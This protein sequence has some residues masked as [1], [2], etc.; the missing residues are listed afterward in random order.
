M[1]KTWGEGRGEVLLFHFLSD[2]FP[3]LFQAGS[4]TVLLSAISYLPERPLLGA[5]CSY[6]GS[7]TNIFPCNY[8]SPVLHSRG[9]KARK[10][11][12]R[13][14]G[15]PPPKKDYTEKLQF[16]FNKACSLFCR[17]F[18]SPISI[19]EIFIYQAAYTEELFMRWFWNSWS[20]VNSVSNFKVQKIL[21]AKRIQGQGLP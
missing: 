3:I 12:I 13:L 5:R 16:R 2:C 6:H 18:M 10:D 8:L 19:G 17:G 15:M 21:E 11:F 4:E 20:K 14:T 9:R 7:T 1:Q